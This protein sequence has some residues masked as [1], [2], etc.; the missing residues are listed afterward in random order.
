MMAPNASA[1]APH[2]HQGRAAIRSWR[3]FQIANGTITSATT[4][5]AT[6]PLA[7]NPSAAAIAA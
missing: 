1:A 5:G 4:T 7:R 2:D 6:G 3:R